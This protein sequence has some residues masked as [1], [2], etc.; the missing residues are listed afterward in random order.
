MNIYIVKV[1]EKT[2]EKKATA[3]EET[4]LPSN[5]TYREREHCA[6]HNPISILFFG[7]AVLYSKKKKKRCI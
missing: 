6:C 3:T 5:Y 4:T 7:K 1:K 2:G